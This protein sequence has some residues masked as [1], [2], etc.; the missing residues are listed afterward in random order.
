MLNSEVGFQVLP[1]RVCPKSE[2]TG[3]PHM[4]DWWG[5]VN[6]Q[7][8]KGK[9]NIKQCTGDCLKDN[10]SIPV[11]EKVESGERCHNPHCSKVPTLSWRKNKKA[12]CSLECIDGYQEWQNEASIVVTPL[13]HLLTLIYTTSQ[14][15][16]EI[17]LSSF[18]TSSN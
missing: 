14:R 3:N 9:W 18:D 16:G 5:P 10:V 2:R 7:L 17:S 4:M 11:K 1:S 13:T 15:E 12:Y 8:S 6:I